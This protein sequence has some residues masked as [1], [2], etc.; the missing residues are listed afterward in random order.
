M[1]GGT[2]TLI[3]AKI[4]K[5]DLHLNF[6]EADFRGVWWWE[7]DFPTVTTFLKI[8]F[9]ETP[10]VH[11][12]RGIVSDSTNKRKN[13]ESKAINIALALVLSQL[14]PSPTTC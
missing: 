10:C 9:P 1:S 12:G 13:F 8:G 11:E 6:P 5:P 3:R 14:L 2:V 7:G 4:G